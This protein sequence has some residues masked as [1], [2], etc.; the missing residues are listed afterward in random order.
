MSQTKLGNTIIRDVELNY[1]KIGDPVSPFGTPQWECQIVVDAERLGEINDLGKVRT[2][3]DG[4]IA[5]NLKRKALTKDGDAKEPVQY[6]DASR[7]DIEKRNNIGNGSSGHVKIY[8]H[9]YEVAGRKGI[10]TILTGIQ[11]IN[12]IEYQGGGA[13]FEV[14]G[15]A[16]SDED[17]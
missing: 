1:V 3:D 8:R 5:V 2:L 11:M 14:E 9:E 4:R 13:D 7:K 6:V 15:E 10:A 17:F 12:L 16:A